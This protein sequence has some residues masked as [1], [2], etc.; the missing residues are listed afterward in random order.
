MI[1]HP[2][3]HLAWIIGVLIAIISAL[4]WRLPN[5]SDLSG[6]ISFAASIASLILAVVAIFQALLSSE[7]FSSSISEI[8]ASAQKIMQE[9]SRLGEASITLGAEADA[10]LK[11]LSDLPDQI[12]NWR[13]EMTERLDQMNTGTTPQNEE[14][15][16]TTSGD[17]LANKSMGFAIAVYIL[18][19]ADKSNK[20]IELDKLFIGKE[21]TISKS[22]SSG[23]INTI[24]Y[25]NICGINIEGAGNNFQINSLGDLDGE[26]I[27]SYMKKYE[28]VS[29][30]ISKTVMRINE[31][32]DEDWIP[33]VKTDPNEEKSDESTVEEN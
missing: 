23:V 7:T 30:I 5:G 24:R 11:R 20:Y 33:K 6:Y 31:Y 3:I 12:T 13:G 26:N 21:F 16:P 25:F 19:V 17:I 10:A 4:L 2:I 32:F 1:K 8:R 18:A 14:N 9:T 22:Y 28:F 15:A 27:I 29:P